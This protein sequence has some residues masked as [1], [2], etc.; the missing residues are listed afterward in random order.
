M[1]ESPIFSISSPCTLF[2]SP[3]AVAFHICIFGRKLMAPL[4]MSLLPFGL[5]NMIAATGV[6]FWCNRF[7]VGWIDTRAVSTQVVYMIAFGNVALGD[8]IRKAVRSARFS[9]L[10]VLTIARISNCSLPLPAAL[11]SLLN[12]REKPLV[13]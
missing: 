1:P 8:L 3:T 12:F 6:F 9:L 13:K 4:A 7:K 10:V 2:A 11:Y 5:P